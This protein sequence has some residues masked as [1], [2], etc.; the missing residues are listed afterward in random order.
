MDSEKFFIIKF[1][2]FFLLSANILADSK[3]RD[4]CYMEIEEVSGG[5]D[6]STKVLK[7]FAAKF[8][9]DDLKI[10]NIAKKS[11]PPIIQGCKTEIELIKRNQSK[12][13][14][15]LQGTIDPSKLSC[16][17]PILYI[18]S[19]GIINCLVDLVSDDD[20]FE[21]FEFGFSVDILQLKNLKDLPACLESE[22]KCNDNLNNGI[23][24]RKYAEWA[25]CVGSAKN[26]TIYLD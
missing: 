6:P 8:N 18:G 5:F 3:N 25:T 22:K 26:T 23:K 9:S 17:R 13:V 4:I 14:P 7:T 10:I 16:T 1:V 15:W 12:E 11:C 2:I 24:S 19:D 21:R 20:G